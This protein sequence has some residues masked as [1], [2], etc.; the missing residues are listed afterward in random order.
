M[1]ARDATIG[2]RIAMIRDNRLMSQAALATAVGTT[3]SI[4][5]HV[6]HGRTRIGVDLAERI[7]TAL[8][9]SLDDLRAPLDAPIPRSRVRRRRGDDFILSW[10][11]LRTTE[12][13]GRD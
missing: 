9:C 5:F 1:T 13:S 8:H 12:G 3:R 4:M 7:A 11:E 6:E 10:N 2:R